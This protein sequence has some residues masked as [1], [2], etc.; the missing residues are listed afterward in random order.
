[1][2]ILLLESRVL[3]VGVI[4]NINVNRLGYVIVHLKII[5]GIG[6]TITVY[7]E[8]RVPA[9]MRFRSSPFSAKVD[10]LSKGR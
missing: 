6:N 2:H 10:G 1:M 8:S 7:P 3:T 9:G 4:P 5:Y